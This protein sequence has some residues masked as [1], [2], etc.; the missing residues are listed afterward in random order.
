M[1]IG[2]AVKNQAPFKNLICNGLVL[3]KDGR[4][5]AKSKGNYTPPMEIV[6]KFGA[7]AVRLYLMNSPLVR[8]ENLR[9]NDKGVKDIIKDVFLPWYNVYRFLI[10]NAERY[11]QESGAK[12]A[13]D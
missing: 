1:V 7:D 9:F 4:K 11:E 3:D 12:F 6:Q 2:T 5:M 10:Q 13:F 8:A